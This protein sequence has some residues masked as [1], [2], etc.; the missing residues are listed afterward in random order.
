MKT[1]NKKRA[2]KASKAI[3]ATYEN[4]PRQCVKEDAIDMLT[5]LRHL[6]DAR[7]WDFDALDRIA[8]QHYTE[9]LS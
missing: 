4:H 6:C 7:A 3:R 8:Y 9:E 1:A 5:D 2:K